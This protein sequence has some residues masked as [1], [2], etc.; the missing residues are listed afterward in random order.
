MG[1]VVELK[2]HEIMNDAELG[3]LGF[4]GWGPFGKRLQAVSQGQ[5]FR[6]TP[7]FCIHP[8]T[9]LPE[10]ALLPGTRVEWNLDQL[11]SQCKLIFMD[12]TFLEFK[13]LL[14]RIRLL[15]ADRHIL[16]LLKNDV[17]FARMSQE[18]N[19]H[20]MVQCVSN[21][22]VNP[23]DSVIALTGSELVDVEDMNQ[24]R[25]C[26]SMF[27][28]IQEVHTEYQL[29]TLERI[30]HL[31]ALTGSVLIEALTDGGGALGLSR[32][33]T[34]QAI[35]HVMHGM[36]NGLKQSENSPVLYKNSL[37]EE[38]PRA[39]KSLLAL[40]KSGFRGVLM[41]AVEPRKN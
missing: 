17:S 11:F 22:P 6:N 23:Q 9:E 19:P 21:H 10:N 34:A 27:S 35:L 39:A 36:V 28:Y 7:V 12:S 26:L 8:L 3:T 5:K 24:V 33:E 4:I 41:E 31:G 25:Q 13:P 16:V 37:L 15:I 20:K 32:E 1:N 38:T 18:I 14:T 30:F 2:T 29:D 40:E